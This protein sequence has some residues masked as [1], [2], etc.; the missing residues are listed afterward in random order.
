MT[1][2]E[3]EEVRKRQK[4]RSVIMAVLLLAFAVLVFAIS[5]AKMGMYGE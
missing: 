3:Q 4:N 5:I 1:P 2:E